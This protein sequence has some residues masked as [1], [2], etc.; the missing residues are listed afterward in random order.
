MHAKEKA[1]KKHYLQLPID[2]GIGI[3]HTVPVGIE[4]K[5]REEGHEESIRLLPIENPNRLLRL[6]S[7]HQRRH[8]PVLHAVLLL[9]PRILRPRWQLPVR[10]HGR[11]GIGIPAVVQHAEVESV[12]EVVHVD[13]EGRLPGG[14]RGGG[15]AERGGG[16]EGEGEGKA[17]G[18]KI[19]GKDEEREGDKKEEEDG[20]VDNRLRRRRRRHCC[21][22]APP[23]APF[24]AID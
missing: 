7:T 10:R 20:K 5:R 13:L 22:L 15:A 24:S 17:A 12:G 18:S 4:T 2:L 21:V 11:L 16:G 1:T 14:S 23:P 6:F 3:S 19:A 9:D 8:H